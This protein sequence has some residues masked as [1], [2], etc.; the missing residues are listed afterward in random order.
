MIMRSD[1]E[2]TLFTLTQKTSTIDRANLSTKFE[3]DNSNRGILV[4]VSSATL[5][6]NAINLTSTTSFE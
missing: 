6:L 1:Q 2:V 4:A 5:N 3:A